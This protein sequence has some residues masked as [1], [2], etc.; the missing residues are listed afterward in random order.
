MAQNGGNFASDGIKA[1]KKIIANTFTG[2]KVP[3]AKKPSTL[4]SKT[5]KKPS[6]A[7][8]KKP[9]TVNKPTTTKKPSTVKKPSKKTS[10]R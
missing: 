8:V 7:T 1:I 2:T 4:A 6:A 9:S 5:V 3:A 10:K